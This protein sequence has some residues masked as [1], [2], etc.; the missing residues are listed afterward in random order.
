MTGALATIDVKDLAGDKAGRL[1]VEDCI[2]DVGDIAHVPDRMQ[3][4][5]R[6]VGLNR[7]H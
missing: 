7:V 6:G 4:P 2:D 5:E 3:S 1:K